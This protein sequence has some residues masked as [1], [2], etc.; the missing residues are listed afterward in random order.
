MTFLHFLFW[1]HFNVNFL[2]F[3]PFYCLRLDASQAD[4]SLSHHIMPWVTL[5]KFDFRNPVWRLAT[6]AVTFWIYQSESDPK[7]Q[8]LGSL[9]PFPENPC[10]LSWATKE[11]LDP[12]SSW[13]HPFA[14]QDLGL[15]WVREVSMDL[16][17]F[18]EATETPPEVILAGWFSLVFCESSPENSCLKGALDDS[19]FLTSGRSSRSSHTPRSARKKFSR[20]TQCVQSHLVRDFGTGR[21]AAQLTLGVGGVS[22][23]ETLKGKKGADGVIFVATNFTWK[24]CFKISPLISHLRAGS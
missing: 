22:S 17:S 8:A 1:L 18:S 19:C 21:C 10:G 4:A 16:M 13:Q 23:S 5:M 2:I 24:I 20:G 11:H 7:H 3:S 12:R 15:L 6:S 9:G 14:W